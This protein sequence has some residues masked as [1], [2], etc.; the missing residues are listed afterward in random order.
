MIHVCF[1]LH[2]KTGRYSKF[3]GTTILSIFEN[4]N[5]EVTAHILHDNTLTAE[6]RDKFIYLAGR[7]GQ[8][9]KFYNVEELCADKIS[10]ILNF[11]PEVKNAYV[12]I[13]TFYRLLIP[14]IIP[15]DVDKIIYLDSD[16]IV[17][18]DIKELWQINLGDKILAAVPE[19]LS[20]SEKEM[21]ERFPLCSYN[22]VRCEDYFNG[23]VL[24]INLN[25]L[26]GEE[27]ILTEALQLCSQNPHMRNFF[28]QDILNFCFSTKALKLPTTFNRFTRIARI[29][30][31][32]LEKKIYHYAGNFFMCG[33]G[34]ELHDPFNR[35]WMNYFINSPWFDTDSIARLYDDVR[36]IYNNLKKDMVNLSAATSGKI[37]AFII[38]EEELDKFVEVFSVKE[39]EEVFV[40]KNGTPLKNI[41]EPMNSSNGE[42]IFFIMLPEFPFN[43]LTEAGFVQG[44]DFLNV[45]DFLSEEH[46]QPLRSYHLLKKM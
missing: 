6:N 35:L 36:Q 31:E 19:I 34:L 12:S 11:A 1:S 13:G 17:K 15:S 4:T 44:K 43:L 5:S 46:G 7:Y 2:D 14:Q 25:L 42:K 27:K 40:V 18:L 41:I 38:F 32:S 39:G 22:F 20:S 23:G 26:R 3:T 37:R 21:Q 29:E 24:V 33:L 30:N 16:I 28:D 10:E 45:Y 8:L 9:V